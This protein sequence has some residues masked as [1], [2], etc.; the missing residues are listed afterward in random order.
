MGFNPGELGQDIQT[1]R[2]STGIQTTIPKFFQMGSISKPSKQGHDGQPRRIT[3]IPISSGQI[4]SD[5]AKEGYVQVAKTIFGAKVPGPTKISEST[6]LFSG[7]SKPTIGE[8]NISTQEAE[9]IRE[10]VHAVMREQ[11]A[12]GRAALRANLG[13]PNE[14]SERSDK[15]APSESVIDL[16]SSSAIAPRNPHP[17]S[18]LAHQYRWLV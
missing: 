7:A 17:Q 8:T 15:A 6:E 13:L 18:I 1:K 2:S 9:T 11:Y 10:E 5:E 12:K 14:E 4:L 16:V 3:P